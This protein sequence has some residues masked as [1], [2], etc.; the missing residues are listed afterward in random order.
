MPTSRATLSTG[1]SVVSSRV[2]ARSSLASRIRLTRPGS[3]S[4]SVAEIADRQVGLFGKIPQHAHDPAGR[5]PLARS[6]MQ[7]DSQFGSH[8]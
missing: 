3:A 6:Q 7:P 8:P 2:F 1:R 4:S 5:I